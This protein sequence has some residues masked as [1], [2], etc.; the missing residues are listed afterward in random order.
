MVLSA[1]TNFSGAIL[2]LGDPKVLRIGR[3]TSSVAPLGA[4]K[5]DR[6]VQYSPHPPQ[7]GLKISARPA[8]LYLV[9][10]LLSCYLDLFSIKIKCD[11]WSHQAFHDLSGLE[12]SSDILEV[13]MSIL[14]KSTIVNPQRPCSFKCSLMMWRL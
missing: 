8:A 2:D 6:L 5:A 3:A 11:N 7:I 9:S 12:M 1:S 10:S 4:G 13:R 14:Q